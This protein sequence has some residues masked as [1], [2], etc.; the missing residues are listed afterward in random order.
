MAACAHHTQTVQEREKLRA[1]QVGERPT[2][3]HSLTTSGINHH[4]NGAAGGPSEGVKLSSSAKGPLESVWEGGVATPPPSSEKK[5]VN[6]P[7]EVDIEAIEELIRKMKEGVGKVRCL[8]V[9]C[10]QQHLS[11]Y[12]KTFGVSETRIPS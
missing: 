8:S 1:Q 4:D 3:S 11:L 10:A 12:I 6:P 7:L 5:S 9:Y 2:A